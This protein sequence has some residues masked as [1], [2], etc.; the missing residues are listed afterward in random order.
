MSNLVLKEFYKRQITILLRNKNTSHI[1]LKT[2]NHGVFL[3]KI[4][5]KHAF[6]HLFLFNHPYF[7]SKIFFIYLRII[8]LNIMKT[9]N[10]PLKKIEIWDLAKNYIKYK[11]PKLNE[12]NKKIK[13]LFFSTLN[14]QEK[15]IIEKLV[16]E[17]NKIFLLRDLM[18]SPSIKKLSA[19]YNKGKIYPAFF[20][21]KHFNL[22]KTLLQFFKFRTSKDERKRRRRLRRHDKFNFKRYDEIKQRNLSLKMKAKEFR[23]LNL[24]T[25]GFLMIKLKLNNIFFT[26]LDF[27]GKT[28]YQCSGGFYNNKGQSRVNQYKVFILVKKICLELKRMRGIRNLILLH[29]NGR[30]NKLIK[31]TLKSLKKYK[32]LRILSEFVLYNRPT[33]YMR[34][35]KVRRV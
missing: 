25:T 16:S 32:I 15:E 17:L 1:L 33:T 20:R 4:K 13:S 2:L 23:L 35:K 3:N 12:K 19:E 8:W 18:G 29:K 28:I 11:L 34:K 24:T 9:E 5:L 21:K 6:V 27:K 7:L 14:T 26:V 30:N 31:F 22:H 10:S